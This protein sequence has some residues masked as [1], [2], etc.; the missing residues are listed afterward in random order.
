VSAPRPLFQSTMP[1][2]LPSPTPEQRRDTA[3]QF[4][5]ANHF[6]ADGQAQP[7]LALLLHCCRIDPANLIYRERLR[8]AQRARLG[9][10]PNTS[11]FAG[12]LTWLPRRRLRAAQRAG[13]LMKV[14]EIAEEVL[15]LD[16]WNAEAH[17]ILA[18]T[19]V[20]AGALDAAIWCLEQAR[21]IAPHDAKFLEKLAHLYEQRGNF[22]LAAQLRGKGQ[23]VVLPEETIAALTD[24]IA[25]DPGKAEPYLNLAEVYRR[26]GQFDR[27][28]AVLQ[29]G[30]TATRNVFEIGVALAQLDIEPFRKDLAIAA[31]KLAGQP[32]DE[33]LRTLHNRLLQEINTREI[34]LYQQLAER[35]PGELGHRF[36][37]GVRLLKA[38]QFDEALA[39]F[40]AARADERYRWR[41]L[42]YG[43]YCHLNRRQWP[44]AARWFEE[45]L[46]LVPPSEEATRRELLALL[47]SRGH[48]PP[49]KA[50]R[51]A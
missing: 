20:A 7:A 6:L 3:A 4:D 46:P 13:D 29:Q 19:F 35:F 48:Q 24:Q 2:P 28:R 42:V 43:G 10:R 14:L 16:P 51:L 22:T 5:R 40:E 18:E 44:L 31:E 25:G 30:M 33:A 37:L 32:Q 36:E 49:D 11:R 45:A 23:S 12:L 1:V 50:R 39:A 15:A 47:A 26:A 9:Q 41:A 27:A 8:H 38:G 17:G 21:E 34:G